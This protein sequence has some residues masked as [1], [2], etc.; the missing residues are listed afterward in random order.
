MARSTLAELIGIVRQY[1]DVGT[2]D[3]T[4]GTATHWA[5]D[6]I[7]TVLDRHRKDFYLSPLYAQATYTDAGSVE[8]KTYIAQHRNLERTDGGTAVFY[9]E[10]SIGADVGTANYSVDYL[11][12]YITF[13]ADQGGT[14]Y[15]ATGRT[16]DV[17]AAAADIWRMKAGHYAKAY[18]VST[19]NHRLSRSQLVKH[20]HEMAQ[21]YEQ[22]GAPMNVRMVRD[23]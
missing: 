2:A 11:R 14:A 1:C 16:Y 3:Y 17:N 12:G 13:S 15:Y 18:D 5:D 4:L 10:T 22:M 8:Y 19:D 7:Q 6:Q 20:C 23:D 9:I 21:M